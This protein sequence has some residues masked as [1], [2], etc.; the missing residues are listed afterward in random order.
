MK[1]VV[2]VSGGVDSVV[3]L[4]MLVRAGEKE[5]IVAHFDHGIR[6]DSSA[7]A[8]FVA[9]LADVYGLQFELGEGKLGDGASEEQAR[10]ARYG[11]LR[12]IAGSSGGRIATAHHQGD[13]IETIAINMTRGTGWRGLAVLNDSSIYRP[14]LGYKKHELYEY[15]VTHQLEWV[16]DETN[17]ADTY[18][19]NR[20]RRRT[21]QLDSTA[22]RKIVDLW[23]SQRK[24]AHAIDQE[25]DQLKTHSRHFMTM[26]DEASACEILRGML[27]EDSL[28]LTRPQRLRLIHAIKTGAAGSTIEAGFGVRV[29]LT[30]GEFIVKH[31]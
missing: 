18:L 27:A 8:R 13:V 29:S 23:L 6:S 19:R 7:D 21:G 30:R 22:R 26:I 14:M 24:L 12:D 3:M 5:L 16:E 20:I 28:A 4:D 15:A 2:A 17:A 9:A 31:P 1:Y 11:F 25:V 10:N